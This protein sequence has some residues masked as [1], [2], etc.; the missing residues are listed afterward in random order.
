MVLLRMPSLVCTVYENCHGQQ[1]LLPSNHL[2]TSCIQEA[3][4]KPK[5]PE[6]MLQLT[7][8]FGVT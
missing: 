4:K 6:D 8:L 7:P 1:Q 3:E 2:T 5:I